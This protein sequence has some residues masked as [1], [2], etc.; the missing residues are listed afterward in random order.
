MA[1]LGEEWF[2]VGDIYFRKLHLY[3]MP[4]GMGFSISQFKTSICQ[5]S[6]YIAMYLDGQAGAKPILQ[7]YTSSGKLVSQSVVS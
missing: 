5:Y 3:D 2:A 7:I 6:G 1:V 4:W